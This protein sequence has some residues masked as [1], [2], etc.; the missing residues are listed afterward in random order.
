MDVIRL[1]KL[2]D[3]RP[4]R[5]IRV[6]LFM[7]EENGTRGAMKYAQVV[8]EKKENHIFALESDAGGFSPRGK[9]RLAGNP[10]STDQRCWN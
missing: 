1:L 5:T 2:S 9:L 3:I 6:V 4:K 10:V 8:A 7:N